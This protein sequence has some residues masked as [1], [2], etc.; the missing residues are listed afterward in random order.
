MIIDYLNK[1]FNTWDRIK[2]GDIISFKD[3]GFT[4]LVCAKQVQL[5]NEHLLVCL[6]NAVI[7][8]ITNKTRKRHIRILKQIEPLKVE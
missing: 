2:T 6:E 5:Q 8:P 7:Y 3:N 1:S 4:Y